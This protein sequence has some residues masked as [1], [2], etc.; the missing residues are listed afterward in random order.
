MSYVEFIKSCSA[1]AAF[2]SGTSTIKALIKLAKGLS[3]LPMTSSKFSGEG[4]A[5]AT[6]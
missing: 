6:G 4:T 5:A 1:S 3:G 2:V